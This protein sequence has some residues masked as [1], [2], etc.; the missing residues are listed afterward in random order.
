MSLKQFLKGEKVPQSIKFK[1]IETHHDKLIVGDATALAICHNPNLEYKNMK[2]GQCYQI[3]KPTAVTEN[4]IM[5]NDKLKPIKI[6]NFTV[7]VK[8]SELVKLQAL[9]P[10]V[11][12]EKPLPA[13]ETS[14]NLMTLIKNPPLP[15]LPI[16]I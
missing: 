16:V 12:Q 13:V 15:K 8:K 14:D 1:V 10:S 6:N 5:P 7:S 3:L 4:E 2:E 9:I 11:S